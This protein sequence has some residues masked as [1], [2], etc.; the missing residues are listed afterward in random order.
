[1][2]EPASWITLSSP[3]LHVKAATFNVLCNSVVIRYHYMS[4]AF[5]LSPE[6]RQCAAHMADSGAVNTQ[7]LAVKPGWGAHCLPLAFVHGR[8]TPF[9]P[10]PAASTEEKVNKMVEQKRVT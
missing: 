3:L 10:I 1:M 9:R 5:F 2:N 7:H 4:G 6:C 8:Y